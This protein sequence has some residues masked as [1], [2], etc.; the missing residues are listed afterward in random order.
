MPTTAEVGTVAVGGHRLRVATRKGPN[1]PGRE[2]RFPLLL[3]NSIGGSPL[4]PGPYRFTGLRRLIVVD[5]FLA[6]P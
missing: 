4:P 5:G 1:G 3:I 2:P 6:G